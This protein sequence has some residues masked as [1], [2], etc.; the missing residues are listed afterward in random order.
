MLGNTIEVIA[1]GLALWGGAE[2]AVDTTLVSPLTR[3]GEPRRRA[4]RF[5]AATLHETGKAKERAYPELLHNSRCRLVVLGIEVAGRWSE[6]AASFI[7]RPFQSCRISCH[8]RVQSI[9][10]GGPTTL[11]NKF[12]N[13]TSK[14]R[15]S[16]LYI[17]RCP[18]AKT[19]TGEITASKYRSLLQVT[20]FYHTTLPGDKRMPSMQPAN[21]D[22]RRVVS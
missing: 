17:V 13:K 10:A 16:V 7:T 12:R 15:R 18:A 21:V 11:R 3:A 6:E 4:G 8:G 22:Q 19:A 20:R 1:N 9:P 5:A 14:L 2:L